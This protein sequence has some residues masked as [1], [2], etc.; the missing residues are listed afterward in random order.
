MS[1][2]GK[3]PVVI[4]AGV[5]VN[6]DADNNVSVKGPKGQLN[7][8]VPKEMTVTMEG[9]ELKVARSSDQKTHRALHG[10]SRTLINNMVVGVT[11]GYTRTL[12]MVGVGYRAQKQ[13]NK[14]VLSVGYSHPVEFVEGNGV[15]FDVPA[16]TKIIING[17]DKQ[18]VGHMAANIRAVRPP[19]PYLGKGIKYSDEVIRRKEGKS[20]KK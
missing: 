15:T 4:P 9:A 12:D 13:G 5:S 20:G 7:W 2:I 11:N 16:P 1:R 10:L 6:I 8:T 18:A 19:E 17:I 14:L 3:L